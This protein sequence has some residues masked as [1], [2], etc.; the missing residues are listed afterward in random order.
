[1]VAEYLGSSLAM[2]ALEDGTIASHHMQVNQK[3]SR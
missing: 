1:M 2:V 3:R